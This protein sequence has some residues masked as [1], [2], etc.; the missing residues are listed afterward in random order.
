MST[1]LRSKTNF[2]FYFIFTAKTWFFYCNTVVLSEMDIFFCSLHYDL[3]NS[4]ILIQRMT[5]GPPHEFTYLN[6]GSA[7]FMINTMTDG[8]RLQK[9]YCL[10]PKSQDSSSA[11]IGVKEEILIRPWPHLTGFKYVMHI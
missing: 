5:V 3:F 7:I 10:T 1:L 11:K 4:I 9:D 2:F 6:Q 8:R